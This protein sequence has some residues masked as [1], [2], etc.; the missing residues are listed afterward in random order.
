MQEIGM[1]IKWKFRIYLRKFKYLDLND[2][3]KKTKNITKIHN[4]NIQKKGFSLYLYVVMDMADGNL[5]NLIGKFQD[6]G[7]NIL[8][9]NN[10]FLF[11][12]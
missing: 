6:E 12:L 10:K 4:F 5:N 1:K 3:I 11:Y 7:K 9:I 2:K 8:Y